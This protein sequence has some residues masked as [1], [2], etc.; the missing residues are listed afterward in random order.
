MYHN[1]SS[2]KSV[3]RSS[4]LQTLSKYYKGAGV[5]DSIWNS[6]KRFHCFTYSTENWVKCTCPKNLSQASEAQFVQPC[7]RFFS[8][9]RLR[10]CGVLQNYNFGF[11]KMQIP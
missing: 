8:K 5:H 1:P 2:N 7:I 9:T 6:L 3:L 10:I 4:D 11:V